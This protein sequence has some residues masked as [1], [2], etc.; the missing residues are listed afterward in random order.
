MSPGSL[1]FRLSRSVL[2]TIS[3]PIPQARKWA[4]MYVPKAG[5]PLL[6]MSQGVPGVPPPKILLD[7]LSKA[8]LSPDACGYCPPTGEPSLRHAMAQEMKTVYGQAAD[9][10]SDDIAITSGCNMA[11]IATVMCLAD[12]GDEIILP[13][14]WYFNHQMSL[15]LLG[16]KAV[17][18]L[19]CTEEGFTP[20]PHTCA[21]LISSKTRAIALVTPNNPTGAIYS[22][23][24]IASFADLAKQH[25]LALIVDETYRDFINPGPPHSLF[26]PLPPKPYHGAHLTKSWRETFVHLFSFSKSYCIPGHR[27]GLIA[28]SPTLLRHI[29]TTLDCLQICP[30]RPPQLAFASPSLLPSLRPSILANAT[31]LV[32]RHRLFRELLPEKWIIGAQGGYFAFVKHP[33]MGVSAYDVCARLA[34]E[35]GVLTLP[36][37]FF[38]DEDME[39][40]GEGGEVKGDWERW[41][42]FSVANVD[43]E[44]VRR[45]CER[46]KECEE[47]KRRNLKSFTRDS[48]DTLFPRVN[49]LIELGQP[50]AQK[51]H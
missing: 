48:P 7:A 42:R 33:F 50:F 51:G 38:C 31:A 8:S 25:N 18:L 40:G 2:S 13:V 24:L 23:A 27:L 15:N 21:S 41:I 43:D 6:D 4:T 16:I 19:T 12:A 10:T 28:A 37:Q 22:P 49:W 20:S 1:A 30:P 39:V 35:V 29:T 17:P 26:S 14:P 32:E 11:F 9:I 46:L 3:P 36:M 47:T 5:R 45:V 34:T 44:K